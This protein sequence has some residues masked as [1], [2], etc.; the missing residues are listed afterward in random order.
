MKTLKYILAFVMGIVLINGCKSGIDPI[1]FV[2]P[3]PDATAPVVTIKYPTEG[4]KV[5]VPTLLAT[6]NIQFEV[7]DD[8]ELKSIAVLMDGTELTSYS[9]FKD[10]R[11]AIKEYSYDKLSNGAHILTIRATDLQG[12]ITNK[13]VNFEKKPP[14]SPIF[15]GEIFYM[16]FDGDYMEKINFV[17]AA[18][19][20]SPGFAGTALKGVNAFAGATDS[21]LTF[22]ANSLKN[23]EFSAAMWIKINPSPDRSG[24]ITISPAGAANFD[25]SRTKG[26][27]LFRE[28]SATQQRYKLNFGIGAGEVWNDGGIVNLPAGWVHI[29]FTISQT[30]SVI[31]I[32]GAAAG[33]A[34]GGTID[35]TGCTSMSIG[36]G[37]P[38][39]ADWNHKFDKSF[40]DELR[41]FNKELTSTEI[42]NIIQY[43]SPYV[44]KYSGEVFYMPFEG[45]YKEL[46]SSAS[47]SKVGTPDFADGKIGKAFKGAIDSY[48][49]FPAANLMK[50]SEFS[51]VWWEKVNTT[52]DRAGIITISPAGAANFDAS[53]T[54]GMRI[55]R[56]GGTTSQQFKANVGFGSGESWNDGGVIN[57]TLGEWVHFAVTIS[58]TQSSIYI[59]GEL[60]RPASSF[61]GGINWTGCTSMSIGSGAPNFA[62]WGHLSDAS[63]IDELRI[64]NKALTQ[65]EIQTIRN[66]EK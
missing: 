52:P 57:P 32:N 2:N 64:F 53:R 10:Y 19:V 5:Q 60:T 49:T 6:I 41:I 54:K 55:F 8:I 13:I 59:N 1:S 22:P 29:A 44:A 39:F 7:T 11:R 37:E 25:A 48:I 24:L 34:A 16:P 20:G 47:A 63:L 56:E 36:S 50:T 3:G 14:Y 31:Y 17:E 43:D 51:A 40:Y 45:N 65:A 35:W 23:A 9:S 27:R 62:D 15:P 58:G 66:A 30:K 42:Q 61:T 4:V 33:T 12:K 18:K 38:Y 26:L 46:N 28:G 21:Y